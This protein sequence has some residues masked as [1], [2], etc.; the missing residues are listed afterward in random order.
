MLKK[1]RISK[2]LNVEK[3]N[4]KGSL[5]PIYNKLRTNIRALESLGVKTEDHSLF[6]IPI[7]CSKISRDLNKKWYKKNAV[8]SEEAEE[9]IPV[10]RTMDGRHV[11]AGDERDVYMVPQPKR[12]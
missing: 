1:I 6:L 4:G 12:K 8:E 11:E 10:R 2:L 3:Y 5:R 7:V 9:A